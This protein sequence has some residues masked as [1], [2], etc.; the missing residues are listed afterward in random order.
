[1]PTIHCLLFGWL[2]LS[3]MDIRRARRMAAEVL[4]Q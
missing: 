3:T 1:L 4:A 2:L